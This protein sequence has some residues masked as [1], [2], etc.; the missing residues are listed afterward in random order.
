MELTDLN[1]TEQKLLLALYSH[2]MDSACEVMPA[3]DLLSLLAIEPIDLNLSFR[4]LAL[5]GLV[6]GQ[7]LTVRGKTFVEESG[8]LP[9]DRWMEV[10]ATRE[11][12]S[13]CVVEAMV[14]EGYT[15]SLN[16][17]GLTSRLPLKPG[18]FEF[19]IDVMTERGFLTLL[20]GNRVALGPRLRALVGK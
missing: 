16:I 8:L 13:I 15:E 18:V 9:L 3:C 10:Q 20:R 17:D 7:S 19:N 1:Q 5:K 2:E 14:A 6:L 4:K 12:I 11:A